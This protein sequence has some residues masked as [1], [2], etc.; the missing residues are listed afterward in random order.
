MTLVCSAL[1]PTS[2]C[3]AET[4]EA[5]ELSALEP[6]VVYLCEYAHSDATQEMRSFWRALSDPSL[7]TLNLVALLKSP[8]PK[9]RSLA[10]FALGH[11]YDPRLL[12]EIAP[13]QSDHAPS[14]RCP[15]PVD[16]H[17]PGKPETWPSQPMTVGDLAGEVVHRYLE[18]SGDKSFS[19]YWAKYKDRS[20]SAAWFILELRRAW[21]PFDPAHSGIDEIRSEIAHMPSPDRQWTVLCLGTLSNPNRVTYPYSEDDLLLA[22]AELGHDR[23]IQ[24]TE[25]Q[26]QSTDPAFAAPKDP[27]SYRPYWERLQAMQIF[28]LS[29]AKVLL[30]SSDAD[31]LLQFRHPSGTEENFRELSYGEWWPIAAASVRPERSTE[32]LD[33]AEKRWSE[34]A[35]IPLSRWRIQ[36]PASLPSI[37]R[38]FYQPRWKTYGYGP[39]EAL[40]LAMEHARPN[41]SYQPLVK[42]ILASDRRLSI[43]GAAMYRFASLAHDWKADFDSLFADWIYAQPPDPHPESWDRPRRLV[44]EVSGV[45]KTLVQDQRFL[46]ADAQLLY[47][48]EQ[49]L[50]GN[51]N[52]SRSESARLGQLISNIDLKNPQKTTESD[53][54]EIRMLLRRAVIDR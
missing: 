47:S 17:P 8:D 6:K 44:V 38:W 24:L 30:R 26:I 39:Q 9:I 33:K 51:L 42:S 15:I 18:V 40:A 11:K 32:I 5:K 16:W 21:D 35:N 10:I 14:Y 49:N 3:S 41:R 19:E 28:V 45:A 23:L 54:A 50:V 43:D 37:L 52:L 4:P 46:G 53:R 34:S 2:S 7:N 1:L 36:G 25:G 31:G 13:L 20:Y 48:I 12:A 29:H 22:S 27:S